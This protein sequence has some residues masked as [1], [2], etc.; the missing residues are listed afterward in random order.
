LS[1]VLT[2]LLGVVAAVVATTGLV[3]DLINESRELQ[4]LV[5]YQGLLLISYFM[6]SHM[7]AMV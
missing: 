7:L 2:V 4:W 6:P 3:K 1:A 5:L